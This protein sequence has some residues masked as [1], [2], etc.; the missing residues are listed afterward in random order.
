M[1][2]NKLQAGLLSYVDDMENAGKMTKQQAAKCQAE[3]INAK[4]VE[5]LSDDL[6]KAAE[7]Y[8]EA[9]KNGMPPWS[10]PL[11]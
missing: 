6:Q 7:K 4:G 3:I 10:R 1:K 5:D 2:W 9:E 8:V 11:W